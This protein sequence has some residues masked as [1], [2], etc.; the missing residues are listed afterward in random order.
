MKYRYW[1]GE[2]GFKTPWAGESEGRLAQ[3]RH[4]ERWHGGIAPGGHREV[5]CRWSDRERACLAVA[6][7][8]VLLVVLVVFITSWRHQL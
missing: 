2:C 5:R 4:Y 6:C 8:V 1:C 3:L 7:A